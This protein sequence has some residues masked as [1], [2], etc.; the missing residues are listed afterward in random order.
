M[1]SEGRARSSEGIETNYFNA[2]CGALLL[3]AFYLDVQL[4]SPQLAEN[5]KVQ[6]RRLRSGGFVSRLSPKSELRNPG[7]SHLRRCPHTDLLRSAR[8]LVRILRE[9][10][11]LSKPL[12]PDEIDVYVAPI[13]LISQLR[14]LYGPSPGKA[15]SGLDGPSGSQ[16]AN[17]NLS[18]TIPRRVRTG[19]TIFV[20]R[21]CSK[22]PPVT[23]YSAIRHERLSHSGPAIHRTKSPRNRESR[24]AVYCPFVSNA[25]DS[26]TSAIRI[27][28]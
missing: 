23:F 13:T 7:L 6:A 2:L 12:F 11:L 25:A 1:P 22:A 4:H 19:P 5:Y 21:G 18:F 14:I 24:L 28:V 26:S 10:R 17:L 16:S 20:T 8:I 15:R 27:C 9:K 3:V